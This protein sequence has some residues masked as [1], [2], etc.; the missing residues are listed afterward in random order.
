MC[1]FTDMDMKFLFIVGDGVLFI[2]TDFEGDFWGTVLSWYCVG[3]FRNGRVLTFM[4]SESD[5][6]G[7]VDFTVWELV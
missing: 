2:S 3:V 7:F 1:F 4:A 6:L 5:L